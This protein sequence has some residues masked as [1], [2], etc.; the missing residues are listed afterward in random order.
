MLGVTTLNLNRTPPCE[1]NWFRFFVLYEKPG[2]KQLFSKRANMQTA[3]M[4]DRLSCDC[5]LL[6]VNESLS[7]SFFTQGYTSSSLFLFYFSFY[8]LDLALASLFRTSVLPLPSALFCSSSKP[9]L[10]PRTIRGF[11]H[12]KKPGAYKRQVKNLHFKHRNLLEQSLIRSCTSFGNSAC[13]I[14]FSLSERTLLQQ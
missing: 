11:Y 9:I 5:Y 8:I 2:D 13:K 3:N 14:A 1:G 4:T 10:N 12:T 7:L 6:P